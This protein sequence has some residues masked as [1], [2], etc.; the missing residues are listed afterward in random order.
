[1]TDNSSSK[2]ET[3]IS[4]IIPIYNAQSTLQACI[5]S[6]LSQSF[7]RY[8]IIL[9]NDGSTDDSK[10]ISERYSEKHQNIRLINTINRG[11]YAARTLGVKYAFGKYVTFLDS[12]DTLKG[13][14]LQHVS[15]ELNLDFDVLITSCKES[16]IN[17]QE[18]FQKDLMSHKINAALHGRFFRSDILRNSLLEI[19]RYFIIGEDL[20]LNLRVSLYANTIKYSQ[21]SIY[22]YN[23]NIES[24][25]QNFKRSW[26]YE[27]AFHQLIYKVFLSQLPSIDKELEIYYQLSFLGGCK[28][29]LLNNSRIDYSDIEWKR[30]K[31]LLNQHRKKLWWDEKLVLDIPSSSFCR[32]LI[33]VLYR[34][35]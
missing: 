12:D 3:L 5:E 10:I 30:M 16:S 15:E 1:M 11:A 6:V 18:G 33:R 19:P 9:I 26:E 23:L 28:L 24:I 22:N 14:I 4:I 34:F 21:L 8:E 13:N 27:R 32:N 20:I 35:I 2:V 29:A 17:T 31:S 7:N 25:T